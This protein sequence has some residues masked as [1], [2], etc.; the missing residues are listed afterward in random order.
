MH[1][2]VIPRVHKGKIAP[3]LMKSETVK[4]KSFVAILETNSAPTVHY[5]SVCEKRK[6]LERVCTTKAWIYDT[7]GK[8]VCT[9]LNMFV[10]A[11]LQS[12]VTNCPALRWGWS[13][14][15]CVVFSGR[16]QLEALHENC[17][18]P[19]HSKQHMSGLKTFSKIYSRYFGWLDALVGVEEGEV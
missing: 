4:H 10:L 17:H 3:Q 5:C 19:F 13:G 2:Y 12:I 14:C 7:A 6:T 1:I 18:K 16:N 9:C 15:V 8:I 11:C